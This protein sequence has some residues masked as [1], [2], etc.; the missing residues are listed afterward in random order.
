MFVPVMWIVWSVFVLFTAVL[1][2]YRSSLTKNE[3]DQIFLDDSFQH[4]Q[5]EQAV[6][7]AKVAKVEPLVRIARWLV[8]VMT[9]VVIAYYVW[10]MGVQLHIFQ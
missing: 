5:A 8:I 1:Y 3:E 6:I 9:V 4:E 7:T 2:I 10:D